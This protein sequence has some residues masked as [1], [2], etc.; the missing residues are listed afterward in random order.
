M[1][2]EL[3]AF[4]HKSIAA[5]MPLQ[6]DKEAISDLHFWKV[7]VMNLAH[8]HFEDDNYIFKHRRFSVNQGWT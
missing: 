6:G 5:C 2:V 3:V 8:T 4:C 7:N 1:Y